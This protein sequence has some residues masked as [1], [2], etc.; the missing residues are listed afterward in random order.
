VKLFGVKKELNDPWRQK[1]KKL[2][3]IERIKIKKTFGKSK[4][5]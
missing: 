1:Y 5:A 4:K 3:L 2:T